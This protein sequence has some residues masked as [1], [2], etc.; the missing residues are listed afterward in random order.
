MKK[1]R[2]GVDLELWKGFHRQARDGQG[3]GL[4]VQSISP[5][6]LNPGPWVTLVPLARQAWGPPSFSP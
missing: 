2:Q 6:S 4:Q 3:T 1:L 5:G